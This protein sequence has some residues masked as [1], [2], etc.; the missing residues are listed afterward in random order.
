MI[1]VIDCCA[2]L[3]KSEGDGDEIGILDAESCFYVMLFIM[4]T[5]R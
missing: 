1:K 4:S 2:Q 5:V 3:L